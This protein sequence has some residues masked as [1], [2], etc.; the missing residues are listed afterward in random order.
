[1]SMSSLKQY[2]LLKRPEIYSLLLIALFA[3]IGYATLNISAMPVY[4]KFSRGYET[5]V[6]GLVLVAFLTS[7]ALFK[8]V[9]GHLA[10]KV[11]RKKLI[12]LGPLITLCTSLLTLWVPH[13]IGCWET[14]FLIIL[15][16]LDGLAVAM[17]WPAAFAM[18]SD[19]THEN[20]RQQGMSLLNTCYLVGI[21]LALPIGGIVN[22]LSGERDASMFLS[23]F[24]FASVSL[25]AF[26]KLPSDQSF[27]HSYHSNGHEFNFQAILE[28]FHR[29]PLFLVL[30]AL[31]FMGISFPMAIIKLFAEQQ[32]GLSESV[33]GFLVLPG[34]VGLALLSVPMSRL[35]EKMG[36]AKAVHYG[37]GLCALGL[38]FISAGAFSPLMRNLIVIGGSGALLGIGFLLAI[39]AWYTGISK[40][41]PQ[42]KAT[43]I[44]AIMTAQGIGSILGA[45]L[46]AFCY[47]YFQVINPIIGRYSPFLGCTLCV[48]LSWFLSL[49][50]FK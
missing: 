31:T 41:D 22:D 45:P 34:A 10:E 39:P 16:I 46:G 24:F 30:A 1:M 29:I 25:V 21:A 6:I 36:Y 4:L 15:R 7:E 13:H 32:F 26:K 27:L 49:K 14:F 11:G 33:F 2:P 48:F 18:M 42:R 38:S 20:E 23:A 17:L 43:N 35:G 44:G 28:S 50:T 19:L 9:M 3:E 12:T 40:I 8:S 5:S 37:T 47:E